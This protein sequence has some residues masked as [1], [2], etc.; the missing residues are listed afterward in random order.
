MADTFPSQLYFV[1][2]YVTNDIAAMGIGNC[3]LYFYKET[4]VGVRDA[5][6]KIA[7]FVD[8]KTKAE[9]KANFAPTIDNLT[10]AH[11][12][13]CIDEGDISGEK[14]EF[15]HI[16]EIGAKA[17]ELCA[18]EFSRLMDAALLAKS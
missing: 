3:W 14:Q 10:D 7:Y 16:D 2:D 4:L 9:T 6:Q 18:L 12:K 5:H 1:R 11:I 8:V 13:E 15:M 17:Q